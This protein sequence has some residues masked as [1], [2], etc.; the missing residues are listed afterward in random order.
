MPFSYQKWDSIQ[1]EKSHHF[2]VYLFLLEIP[3][4]FIAK[5][6]SSPWREDSYVVVH[7]LYVNY[8]RQFLH[9]KWPS[10]VLKTLFLAKK[11]LCTYIW[12]VYLHLDSGDNDMFSMSF[13]FLRALNGF[14]RAAT[15]TKGMLTYAFWRYFFKK[16]I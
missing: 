11:K 12:V 3:L 9:V 2:Y 15:R 5:Q 8:T 4:Y 16:N 14:A 7:F 1:L 10:V 6:N 13:S